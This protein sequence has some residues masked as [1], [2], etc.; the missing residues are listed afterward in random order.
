MKSLV[1]IVI[2]VYNREN[3]IKR[4]IDSVLCQTYSN[5]EVIVIDDCST[6][7]SVKILNEYKD[8]RIKVIC[9]KQHG[10]ANKA[11]NV[12][13]AI[14]RGEYIAFQDSDDE[15]L[16]DKLFLQ[17]EL[18]K[19]HSFMACYCPYYLHEKEVVFPVPYDYVDLRKYQENL[20]EILSRH[21][22]VGTSTLII[23]REL[24]KLLGGYYFDECM[25]RWQDYEFIIRIAKCTDI[26]YVNTPLVNAYRVNNSITSDRRNLYEAVSQ[27]IRKHGDFIRIESFLN[28]FI[29]YGDIQYDTNEI[30]IEGLNKIQNV[31]DNRNI[32][33]KDMVI[34]RLAEEKKN[35]KDIAQKEFSLIVNTLEDKS[36]YIYGAGKVGQKLYQELNYRGLHPK[37]FIVS[38]CKSREY[39]YG[40]PVISIDECL[41]KDSMVIIGIAK[42]HRTELMENLIRKKFKLFCLYPY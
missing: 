1:S 40:I 20:C 19:V 5:I 32:N 36:F 21:S 6:D 41:D 22:V 13:I 3:T 18:M 27:I 4:A 23:R 38:E 9:Q 8:K 11:R 42:M 31:I 17:I 10:G 29:A 14:A 30:L 26:G 35:E 15:W 12:G 28:D 2:P 25:L 39:I 24:L 16:P 7:N 34:S 33:I 37:S